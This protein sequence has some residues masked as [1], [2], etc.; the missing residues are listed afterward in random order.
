MKKLLISILAA[1]MLYTSCPITFAENQTEPYTDDSSV[2][3]YVSTSEGV[4]IAGTDKKPVIYVDADDWAGV[5]RAAG[6]LKEDIKSVTDADASVV[7]EKSDSVNVLIG[8]IGKSAEI[9]ALIAADKLD[10]SE[11]K[12]KWECFTIK[13]IDG[14]IVI[15]GSDK[16]GT[17]YGIY[18][19]SEKMGVSPWTFWA[20]T[21]PVHQDNIY[22]NLD[23]NG[24]TEGEPSVQ[25]RGIFLNDEYNL[26]TWS[27]SLD[28]SGNMNNETYKKIFEL[29]LRLK[30]N[31]CW[32]AMHTYSTA[33][34][35]TEHNAEIADEYG[36][37]MG[38]S[39]C[40][41]LL[42]N[43]LGE[44]Y[45]YQQE[46]TEAHPDKTLY[47]NTTDDA[48]RNVSWMWT[49][50]DSDGNAVDNKEFLKDYWRARVRAN[51]GY[52]NTYTLGMR[53]VHDGKFS[54][55]MNQQTAMAEIIAAQREIL[56]EELCSD[57]KEITDIPQVF[58]PYKEM[59]DLYNGGLKIPDE[60]TLMWADD[61]FG[62]IRQLPTEAERARSGGAGVYY[63]LS[64][65]G[66]P[67]S[68]LWL[69]TTQLGLIRE[70]MTKAYDM[71]AQKIWIANVGDL[72]PAETQVEYFLDL[73]RDVDTVRNVSLDYYLA[74]HAKRD[75]GFDDIQA[76]EYADIQNSFYEIANSRRPEH[77]KQ[78]LF[79]LENFGDE[80]QRHID[81][82]KA[83][84][85]RSEALYNTLDES[86]KPSFF[87]MQL[88]P[89]RCCYNA[90][91]VYVN[92]DKAKL[93]KEQGRGMAVNKYAA[94]A[95]AASDRIDAD[96][97]AYN[98]MLGGK[99]NKIMTYQPAGLISS[100]GDW[101]DL[102]PAAESVSSVD[103]TQMG[104]APEGSDE[105]TFDYYNQR[106]KFIDIYNKGLGTIDYK[107]TTNVDWIKLNKTEATVADD[108][109]IY[110]MVD[111]AKAPLGKS[112]AQITVTQYIG[113]TAVDS[114][115]VTVRLTNN[116]TE[117]LGEKTYVEADGY[118][119]I[120]A[121]HYTDS[122]KNG[123][124]EWKLEDGFGRSGD[125][126]K[127]Y[128]AA[129]AKVSTPD[130]NN[131]AYLEYDV[132]FTSSG[133]FPIDV[134]RMPSINELGG[135]TL[136]CAVGVDDGTPV[137]FNGNTKTTDGSSGTDAWGKGVLQNADIISGTITVPS[138]GLHTIRLYNEDAGVVIDK[139]VITTGE[140]KASYYGAPE[141]YNTYYNQIAQSLPPASAAA[142]AQTGNAAA[143][144]DASLVTAGIETADDSGIEIGDNSMKLTI[145]DTLTESG[146]GIIAAYNKDGTLSGMT[147]SSNKVSPDDENKEF[148]FDKT[149][150][151]DYYEAFVWNSLEEMKP[152]TNKITPKVS[153]ISS[154]K[155]VKV[156]DI[157]EAV[158]LAAAYDSK[159]E[160]ITNN[161]TA[162]DLSGVAVNGTVDIPLTLDIPSDTSTVQIIMFDSFDNLNVLAP[163]YKK[164]Y[165]GVSL[166]A[167]YE[168]DVVSAKSNLYEYTGKQSMAL[169]VPSDTET[170]TN[171]DI[172]YVG[173]EK[174][175]D[176]S[177]KS[178][179]CTALNGKYTLKIGIAGE[180]KV[181]T[182]TF[183]TAKNIEPDTA[184]KMTELYNWSFDTDQTGSGTNVPVLGGN[185]IYDSTNKCIKMTSTAAA[186]GSVTV[187]LGTAVTAAQGEKI[188]VVSKIAYGNL[189]G[190]YMTY[191]LTDSNGKMLVRSNI[192]RYTGKT[193]SLTIGG[194]EQL[195][196][197]AYPS[198]LQKIDNS[199]TTP[200]G[201]FSIY[202]TVIDPASNE[203]KL[204]IS[205]TVN[206]TV[207]EYTGKLPEGTSYDLK[208][209]YFT[210]DYNNAG[211]TCYV[212]DISITRSKAEAYTI[213]FMPVDKSGT[214]VSNVV[215]TVTDGVTGAVIAS[216]A[217][218]T[219]TLCEGLYNYNVTADGKSVS[220]TLELSQATESKTINVVMN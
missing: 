52:D 132:Y 101:P 124:Y 36:I 77:L 8:T 60:V 75:F 17:I 108:D 158:A 193:Q 183:N 208:K 27:T 57:G 102:R 140:K 220:D 115:A 32:P 196:D 162:V 38:S 150:N 90:T 171:D 172:I 184:A 41:P 117:N 53:G 45:N 179:P 15:A 63:H 49:D 216:G 109:R 157:Q 144:F 201:K 25:Y 81:T 111:Y 122:V 128:P 29:L 9:D 130:K 96:T 213:T 97:A 131:S 92:T 26:T 114:K 54:T 67:T 182:E 148:T 153:G 217:D 86:R 203:I 70:E 62:Y 73:A 5:V 126:V 192:N 82:Y 212:D 69:S 206:S 116:K 91:S 205:N 78:G 151:G 39:H 14:T 135:S 164:T 187:D 99:W 46:W 181:Y 65:R 161:F 44:L 12:D 176:E 34:N 139:M 85:E 76:G 59:L 93:Y 74:E 66:K 105:L 204:T 195:T 11:I 80:G 100:Y 71:G 120:E 104:I 43:N 119:S 56:T 31:Y 167:S 143:T 42:R 94:L 154:V 137:K 72:K 165:D 16:R 110:A 146:I 64:Y 202:T 199:A 200:A 207:N 2:S 88:Y 20:D 30:A 3:G 98:S 123:D 188:T 218:G 68:Y 197:G 61:N 189:S 168:N 58:I 198:A 47:I 170:I 163:I 186:G 6:D 159:G 7:N 24:Y 18:D 142:T 107:V 160:L 87:E 125:S 138:A 37:V 210:T 141:S 79:S 166:M 147:V 209:L 106:A 113:D 152:L 121:E 23:E 40:E 133:K 145:T 28:V 169:I 211:R 50:K 173:Q 83:L 190:K 194:I 118:V 177:Y 103:Y 48:K 112:T 149:V 134:Y 84:V 191:E 1:A 178:I 21:V 33:F 22:I 215:I 51:G 95:A 214:A 155:A 4:K 180:N 136:R 19:L 175:T 127:I 89:L 13:N 174:V 10:V 156:R 129:G 35:N 55:N 219:Y 185:A